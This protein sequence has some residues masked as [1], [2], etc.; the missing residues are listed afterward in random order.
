MSKVA[1][2][3]KISIFSIMGPRKHLCKVQ[4]VLELIKKMEE[5]IQL[6]AQPSDGFCYRV[7]FLLLYATRGF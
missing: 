2:D 3:S 1:Q 7:L 5:K 4:L 6:L